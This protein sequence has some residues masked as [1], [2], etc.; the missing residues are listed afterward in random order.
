[1]K[2][3]LFIL[4]LLVNRVVYSVDCH[5]YDGL[6]YTT[7]S[8]NDNKLN[9]IC[10]V[11]PSL[12]PEMEDFYLAKVSWNFSDGNVITENITDLS[13][14]YSLTKSYSYDLLN[15][16][17]LS[18]GVFSAEINFEIRFY[19][20]QGQSTTV[21]TCYTD[22]EYINET[23]SHSIDAEFYITPHKSRF[24]IG[25]NVKFKCDFD[26]SDLTKSYTYNLSINKPDGLYT[27]E[28]EPLGFSG[29]IQLYNL[30]TIEGNYSVTFEILSYGE[31]VYSQNILF[32][33]SDVSSSTSNISDGTCKCV[34]NEIRPE[35]NIRVKRYQNN[36]YAL[37]ELREEN[38][39]EFWRIHKNPKFWLYCIYED[40]YGREAIKYI[41]GSKTYPS[42]PTGYQGIVDQNFSIKLAPPG[43]N[44]QRC[45]VTLMYKCIDDDGN[46]VINV[47]NSNEIFVKTQKLINY[48]E[49]SKNGGILSIQTYAKDCIGASVCNVVN[50]SKKIDW[51]DIST[52]YDYLTMDVEPNFE[53]KDRKIEISVSAS[54]YSDYVDVLNGQRLPYRTITVTQP[55]NVLDL[56]KDGVPSETVPDF[57][58]SD[59]TY[60]VIYSENTPQIKYYV[61]NPG[62][63]P[64]SVLNDCKTG[65]KNDFVIKE[66]SGAYI[67]RYTVKESTCNSEFNVN[68]IYGINFYTKTF[69]GT[70]VLPP[71][72]VELRQNI[73][74]KASKSLVFKPGFHAKAGSVFNASIGATCPCIAI[75]F[76]GNQQIDENCNGFPDFLENVQSISPKIEDNNPEERLSENTI[77]ELNDNV[78]IVTDINDL[79]NKNYDLNIYPNPTS[80]IVFVDLK[81]LN[82]V[83]KVVELISNFGT[84]IQSERIDGSKDLIEIELCD[85]PAG[86]YFVRVITDDKIYKGKVIKK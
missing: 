2:R 3:L 60:Y 12:Y 27:E 42:T 13:K 63:V 1:M 62:K 68:D 23:V 45:L 21:S 18:G 48:Y 79:Q 55:T 66:S 40:E 43:A 57:Y 53:I 41:Y 67:A 29:D 4:L 86:V 59:Y 85:Y 73:K 17:L 77:E 64:V 83:T 7:T 5:E 30:N 82:K 80:D 14:L 84:I 44:P 15:T 35:L 47:A 69:P 22:V 24:D 70:K 9:V 28:N 50:P 34:E 58:H 19:F 49:I 31:I 46:E 61:S 81:P 56:D 51:I 54:D 26:N 78:P 6:I 10:K 36:E 65:N 8:I 25:E 32:N 76:W 75:D 74:L 38:S 20:N 16:D 71:F 72:T 11:N 39:A 33:C 37:I 52:S